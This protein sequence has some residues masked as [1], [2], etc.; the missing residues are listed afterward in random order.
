MHFD[1]IETRFL[2][3]ARCIPVV[4]NDPRD[5]TDFKRTRHGGRRLSSRL[6]EDEVSRLD[7]GR[8][9]WSSTVLLKVDMR[10][11]SNVP[12]LANDLASRV[13]HHVSDAMP[14][15]DMFVGVDSW[16]EGV[17]TTL[18]R[19][20]GRLSDDEAGR[21]TLAIVIDGNFAMYAVHVGARTGQWSHRDAVGGVDGA[22][23][24]RRKESW[25]DRYWHFRSPR[26]VSETI[27]IAGNKK[28]RSRV[29]EPRTP[30]W[31]SPTTTRPALKPQ[32]HFLDALRIFIFIA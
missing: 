20:V 3:L 7:G 29:W 4:V 5:F 6:K 12:E 9:N 18:A 8:R 11:P 1:A 27:R 16:C 13:M 26:K 10:H 28:E 21:R 19:Y 25:T 15:G 24:C 31:H 22:N 17:A 2:G 32:D 14:G 23:H 30:I